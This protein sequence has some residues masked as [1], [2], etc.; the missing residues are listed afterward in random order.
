MKNKICKKCMIEKPIPSFTKYKTSRNIGRRNVCKD[1]FTKQK[2]KYFQEN[3][4]SCLLQAL[5][6]KKN[7]VESVRESKRKWKKNNPKAVRKYN[8]EYE[9]RNRDRRNDQ[10]KERRKNDPSYKISMNLRRAMIRS[11]IGQTKAGSA[12]RDL[13]CSI[14]EFRERFEEMF[15]VNK[16]TGEMMSWDNYGHNGWHID[17][18]VPL[19]SFD[20]TNREQ[21]LKA[22][23][24]SNLQPLWWF[25]NLTKG[26]KNVS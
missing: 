19:V 17:H 9:I 2:A 7:N 3:K 14:E 4:E 24:Y 6:W 21:F 22:C 16:K 26:S 11:L 18:I 5:E 12:V 8:R 13:G 1:C 25:D 23:H 15:Y 10:R 20:L